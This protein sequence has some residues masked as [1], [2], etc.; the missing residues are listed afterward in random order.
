MKEYSTV[1]SGFGGQ[2]VILAGKIIARTGM[3]MGLEVT[4][5]PSYGPEMRGGTANCT[6]IISSD[7]IGSPIVDNPRALIAMNPPSLDKFG[8]KVQ[9]GGLIVVNTS[10]VDDPEA[11]A[12]INLAKVPLNDIAKEIGNPK[13]I[14]MVALGAWARFTE[15]IELEDVTRG[16]E[17]MLTD[18]GKERFVEPNENALRDGYEYVER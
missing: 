3:E 4:W 10:L 8:E 1:I 18:M 2:G 13:V 11:Q 12:E 16:M 5:L 15:E 9:T 14:N 6:A 17:M 7:L